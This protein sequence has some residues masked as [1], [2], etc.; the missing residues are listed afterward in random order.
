M[1]NAAD[2]SSQFDLLSNLAATANDLLADIPPLPSPDALPPPPAAHALGAPPSLDAADPA[3]A[4]LEPTA[5][6]LGVSPATAELLA[7]VSDTG[8]GWDQA[9]SHILSTIVTSDNLPPLPPPR[10]AGRGRGRPRGGGGRR[11]GVSS[12]AAAAPATPAAPGVDPALSNGV[13]GPPLPTPVTL[14]KRPRGRPK[15]SVTRK[16]RK[17]EES[18]DENDND[19][20]VS[21]PPSDFDSDDDAVD[22]Y[23]TTDGS[24][25]RTPRTN[26]SDRSH[27]RRAAVQTKFGRRVLRPS[28]F[29]PV[30]TSPGTA[31]QGRRGGARRLAD[32]AL[33]KKCERGNS[34]NNNVVV[35]CDGCGVAYHQFCHDPPIARDVVD[36]PEKEWYCLDCSTGGGGPAA[37]DNLGLIPGL[38]MSIDEVRS[39]PARC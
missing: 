14:G 35:F 13:G 33:C 8:S 22:G 10:S 6:S 18:D 20:S 23:G 30:L 27:S 9:R 12:T 17:V 34:P 32:A 5:T 3:A 11:R 16:K 19:G 2:M 26:D 21:D 36:I 15:G 38:N 31:R 7:R 37:P 24:F 25:A 4:A 1:S 29:V 28:H 39:A